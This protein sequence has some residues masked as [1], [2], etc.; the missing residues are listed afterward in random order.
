MHNVKNIIFIII[1]ISSSNINKVSLLFSIIDY[2]IN[3][4]LIIIRNIVTNI[5]WIKII[6]IIHISYKHYINIENV[7]T[8]NIKNDNTINKRESTK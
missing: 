8:I 5:Y 7:N 1:I 4:L 3:N 2:I 6:S